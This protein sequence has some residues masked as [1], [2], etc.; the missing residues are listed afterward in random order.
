VIT[1]VSSKFTA[2]QRCA[3][4][5][6]TARFRMSVSLN[7]TVSCSVQTISPHEYTAINETNKSLRFFSNFYLTK[8]TTTTTTTN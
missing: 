8:Q 3:A 6:H 1:D 4:S 2:L 7:V 5:A